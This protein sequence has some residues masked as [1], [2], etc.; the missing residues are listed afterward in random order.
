MNKGQILAVDD[1]P[2]TLKLLTELLQGEGYSVR[3]SL[4]GKLALQSA[5]ANPPEIILLDV[6]MPGM[7]GFEVC[8]ELKAHPNTAAV[9]VIFI[10]GL[11]DVADRVEGFRLGAAD[12]VIKPFQRDELLARVKTQLDVSRFRFGLEQMVKS[13][14]V[15]LAESEARFKQ[16]LQLSPIPL[17]LYSESGEVK[18]LNDAFINTFGYETLDVPNL[19]AW[20]LKA[21]PDEQYR[22]SLQAAWSEHIRALCGV[23]GKYTKFPSDVR[24]RTKD[25]K[26]LIVEFSPSVI[27]LSAGR[28][29]YLVA[30]YDITER[31]QTESLLRRSEAALK[32]AQ[33]IA[34]LGSWHMDLA[35]NQV[36]WSEELY[37][38]Y[39]FD[40]SE[41]PPLYTESMQLF[42]PESWERLSSAISRSVEAG[43]D[44]ELELELITKS[45][46]RKWMLARGEPVLDENH[47][48][49]E[50]QGVVMDITERKRFEEM[51]WR[52]ANFD[53]LTGLPNR[54][55]FYDRMEQEAKKSR[56]ANLPMALLL[57]DLDHFKE[58]NDT[59]G[60]DIGDLMLVEVANRLKACIRTSD[61]VARLG[62]DEFV[63]ILPELEDIHSI[64]RVAQE[65]I[66]SLTKPFRI[67]KEAAFITASIGISLYP[68]DTEHLDVLFRNADQALYAAKGEGRSR[69]SYFTQELQ[70][71]ASER[72]YLT[73][74]LRSALENNQ[75]K[76]HYQPIIELATGKLHKAEALLRWHHPER[77]LISP[78]EFIPLAEETGLIIPIGDWVFRQAVEQ[79]RLWRQEINPSF[80]ISV[81]KSPVQILHDDGISWEDYLL[82]QGISGQSIAVEITE[83]VLLNAKGRVN[84]RLLEMRDAGIQVAID[85]FG[86]GYS[87][88]AY[89]K[90]FHIDYLKI[91][92]SFVKNLGSEGSALALCEAII[93]MAHKLGFKVI[94]EG[95]ETSIQRDLLTVAGCDYVQGYLYSKPVPPE[96]FNKLLIKRDSH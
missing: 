62:G 70:Q 31:K 51:I 4:S 76:V 3:S 48:T 72:M 12:F 23:A 17:A 22:T 63:V 54:R 59:R 64:E 55:M 67:K 79:A 35:T 50:L 44:Y 47:K 6:R 46:E 96:E 83:G 38:L 30:L 26:T 49:A 91:D 33:R 78:S 18:F 89:L 74:D 84:E 92:Q 7:N 69:F 2:A 88:L 10:S 40:S 41:P 81:N 15:E 29:E 77:G 73:T 34:H 11:A 85:D 86:T 80:Q 56:R 71:A 82:Q 87:S 21:Y 27:S 1:S 68:S 25:G 93:V 24:V 53:T 61:T 66:C 45:G 16:I 95:V 32:E 90:E 75:F 36:Y 28:V 5:L 52:Q 20:W 43:S 8:Q 42:T 94:A 19:D 39:G 65:I 13:R 60:H 14:T 37:K 9:P 57:I 58:V